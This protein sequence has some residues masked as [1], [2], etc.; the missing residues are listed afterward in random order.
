MNR[1]EADEYIT[2]QAAEI[3]RLRNEIH[4]WEESDA[5]GPVFTDEIERLRAE[6]DKWKAEYETTFAFY[7]DER[8]QLDS[9]RAER[10]EAVK[11]LELCRPFLSCVD[12]REWTD[13]DYTRHEAAKERAAAVLAENWRKKK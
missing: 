8:K 7:E 5:A 1:A 3:E 12:T 2:Q 9:M 10:D 13:S 6:R 4:E 11:A